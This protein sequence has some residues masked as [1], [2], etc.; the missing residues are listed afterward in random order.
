M[1]EK[2]KVKL[3]SLD[4][5]HG[6]TERARDFDFPLAQFVL[7][8]KNSSILFSRQ[9]RTKSFFTSDSGRYL[10]PEE[11]KMLRRKKKIARLISRLDGLQDRYVCDGHTAGAVSERLE[12]S[13]KYSLWRVS[14]LEWKLQRR[15]ENF[16]SLALNLIE[17]S[18]RK[19]S[20]VKMWNL[21]IVGAII[22]GMFTMTM[23]YRYLGQ[24]VSAQIR[25]KQIAQTQDPDNKGKIVGVSAENNP[26]VRIDKKYF[27]QLLG[28][29]EMSQAQLEKKIEEMVKGYPIE[30][31]V[32]L[33]AKKDRMVAAFMIGI[34]RQE[35]G[36]GVHV[37]V[38]QGRDCYNYWGW[39]GKNAVG[40]G[41]HTCFG[42]LE[43]AVNTV[44]K[45]LEFL[46]SSKKLNTP[47][48]MIIWKCGDC[49][50]DNQRD[51]NNWINAVSTYFHKL[52]TE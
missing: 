45:R 4:S 20:L 44:A 18:T 10:T 36:W 43:D 46:V 16:R 42:S 21:S 52:N 30:K 37:P 15:Y 41:G 31:M 19:I 5:L 14:R 17:N 49:S 47:R 9:G 35:S 11:L 48:K 13:L 1:G 29:E 40:T 8:H 51:M 27:T 26:D 28:P 7:K 33:I 38:Y 24:S 32:P 3:V 25:E 34:A 22:F 2:Q 50:W 6:K 12:N 39:R 23:I